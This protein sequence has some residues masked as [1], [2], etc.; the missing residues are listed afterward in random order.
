[1]VANKEVLA[2]NNLHVK[3]KTLAGTINAVRGVSYKLY[4]G[5]T[6]ALVGESGSGKSVSTKAITRVLP[7]NAIVSGDS[8][9]YQGENLLE[10]DEK[11]LTKIRGNEIAMIFQDPMTSLN[12]VM[13][14]GYQIAE[15][16]IEHR[17]MSKTEAKKAAI[18]LMKNVGIVKA[19]ERYSQY[20]HQF[21][22]GLR[23]RVMIALA[24]ACPRKI[25]IADEPTTA[26]D[27]T[28]PAPIIEFLNNLN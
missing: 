5:E 25:M 12:P 9:M 16:M 20:P 22:G 18:D 15:P 2:L 13:T 26:L 23:Q 24:V 28:I 8:I 4:Q 3:F 14:V 7:K 21:T 17:Q 11:A 1:M 19:E 6:L 10:K 27:V